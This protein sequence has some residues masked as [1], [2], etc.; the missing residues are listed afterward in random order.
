M[1]TCLIKCHPRNLLS[2][3]KADSRF[4]G[5]DDIARLK[6]VFL[7]A[8]FLFSFL[9]CQASSPAEAETL[10][11]KTGHVKA[12]DEDQGLVIIDLGRADGI[13]KKSVF[14]IEKDGEK[15]ATLEVVEIRDVLTACRVRERTGSYVV[16]LNDLVRIRK[17]G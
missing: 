10:P 3:I 9:A 6:A 5:N 7:G 8:V 13:E 11:G 4:R 17:P 15:V 16:R 1:Q 2:G 14:V 12:V